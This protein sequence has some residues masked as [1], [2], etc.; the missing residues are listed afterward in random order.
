ML[1]QIWLIPVL[2]ALGALING[3]FGK[4][5]PKSVIH[6]IA[7]GTVFLS[8]LISIACVAQLAAIGITRI[9]T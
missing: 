7:C 1:D 6:T 3:I 2:P 8:L 4:R 5:L 9:R